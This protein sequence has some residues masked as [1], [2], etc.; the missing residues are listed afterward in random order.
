[1]SATRLWNSDRETKRLSGLI[2]ILPAMGSS[3]L[4]TFGG[5]PAP[6]YILRERCQ[7]E[8]QGLLSGKIAEEI[9]RGLLTCYALEYTRQQVRNRVATDHG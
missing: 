5:V 6:N 9:A 8:L 4:C 3:K 2:G 7:A 1:M